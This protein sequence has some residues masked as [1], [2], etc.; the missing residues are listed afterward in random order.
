MLTELS[1]VLL[2]L[3][4]LLEKIVYATEKNEGGSSGSPSVASVY[5]TAAHIE[6]TRP[7]IT[8]TTYIPSTVTTSFVPISGRNSPITLQPMTRTEFDDVRRW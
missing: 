1:V 8:T 7:T 4:D 5:D 2:D 6:S 3:V